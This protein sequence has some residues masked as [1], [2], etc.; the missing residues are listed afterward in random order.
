[1]MTSS[2]EYILNDKYLDL[3]SLWEGNADCRSEALLKYVQECLKLVTAS[4]SVPGDADI[5]LAR[6]I[7]LDGIED[8]HLLCEIAQTAGEMEATTGSEH[9]ELLEHLN[10]LLVELRSTRGL[11]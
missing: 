11:E 8:D 4:E 9:S 1:M 2:N 5:A 3:L 6:V 7:F 10:V